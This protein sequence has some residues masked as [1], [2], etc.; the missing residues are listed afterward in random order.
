MVYKLL[1]FTGGL[2]AAAL[3]VTVGTSYWCPTTPSHGDL[4]SGSSS[5]ASSAF[6][7][8]LGP[9]LALQALCLPMNWP[10]THVGLT[11]FLLLATKNLHTMENS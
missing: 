10:F 1:P 11:G 9:S 4:G 8:S 3:S 5:L 6:Y 7:M 2:E